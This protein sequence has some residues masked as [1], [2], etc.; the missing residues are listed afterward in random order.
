MMNLYYQLQSFD[1]VVSYLLILLVLLHHG[2]TIE[3]FFLPIA[4]SSISTSSSVL[5]YDRYQYRTTTNKLKM[6]P[7]LLSM[8]Y[9]EYDEA[10]ESTLGGRRGGLRQRWSSSKTSSSS[11]RRRSPILRQVNTE[12]NKQLEERKID[13]QQ[14]HQE[15]LNDPTLLSTENF[16][17]RNDISSNSKRSITEIMGLQTMTKVQHETYPIA[18]RGNSILGHSRT[19]T[20]KTIGK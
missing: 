10:L 7:M 20:G 1:I 13:F 6:S 19:G 12:L 2:V 15:A 5:Y 8:S 4:P 11:G 3:A 9:D 14:R 18:L 16:T 17:D